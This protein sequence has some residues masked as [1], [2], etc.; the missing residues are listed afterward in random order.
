MNIPQEV[1]QE[2]FSLVIEEYVRIFCETQTYS[3]GGQIYVQKVG[4]PIGPRA[5]SAIARI[6]MK[7][8]DEK[9][10]EEMERLGIKLEFVA[11]RKQD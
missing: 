11:R 2:I 8:L 9:M 7:K 4:L 6:V 10:F 1:R 5:T 3:W